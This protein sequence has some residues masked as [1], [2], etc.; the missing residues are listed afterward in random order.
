LLCQFWVELETAWQLIWMTGWTFFWLSSQHSW[1]PC[2]SVVCSMVN[3]PTIAPNWWNRRAQWWVQVRYF[4][5]NSLQHIHNTFPMRSMDQ[6]G[7]SH[8]NTTGTILVCIS[9]NLALC[10]LWEYHVE[11]Q[12]TSLWDIGPRVTSFKTVPYMK[13]YQC[14]TSNS[15]M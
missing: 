4:V 7:H 5:C 12:W 14:F 2:S 15:T 13:V 3:S 8:S 1:C 6:R 11:S 10:N 9:S